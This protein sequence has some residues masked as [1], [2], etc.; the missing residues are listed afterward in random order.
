MKPETKVLIIGLSAFAYIIYTSLYTIRTYAIDATIGIALIILVYKNYERFHLTPTSYALL[1]LAL[2]LH[3]LGVSGYYFQSPVFLD[4]DIVTHTYGLFAVGYVVHQ[5]YSRELKHN[6]FLFSFLTALGI[7]A[8]VE[9][10]EFSGFFIM[11]ILLGIKNGFVAEAM[12]R[13]GI[14]YIDT[15]FDLA[16]DL[17]GA[18]LGISTSWIRKAL[19]APS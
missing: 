6:Q 7:G 14:G 1:I 13:G 18:V 2:F 15:M 4:W 8:T 11:N 12:A 3:N 9:L 5:Y 19:K 17:I 16:F 10:A